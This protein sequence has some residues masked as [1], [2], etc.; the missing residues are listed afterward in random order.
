MV[1]SARETDGRQT[2]SLRE[3]SKKR[4]IRGFREMMTQVE[5]RLDY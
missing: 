3:K 1:G 2:G 5:M 4:K